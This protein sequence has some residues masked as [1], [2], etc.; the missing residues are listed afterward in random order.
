MNQ[1][2]YNLIAYA[3]RS[4]K[5][6]FIAQSAKLGIDATDILDAIDEV[7]WR[8]SYELANTYSNFDGKKFEEMCK[9]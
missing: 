6:Q 9:P 8:M 7:Q 1:K 5:E 2:E 3:I 4:T